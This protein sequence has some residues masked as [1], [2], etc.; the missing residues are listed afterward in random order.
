MVTRLFL[1]LTIFISSMQVFANSRLETKP[2]P[3]DLEADIEA[4]RQAYEQLRSVLFDIGV[5][6]NS[7]GLFDIERLICQEFLNFEK[8]WSTSTAMRRWF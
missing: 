6:V 2:L 1:T 4:Q 5:A 3:P 8:N 7:E